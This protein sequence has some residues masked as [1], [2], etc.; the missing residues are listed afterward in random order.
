MR[1]HRADAAGP[2]L[3]G[4]A[5]ALV[6]ARLHLAEALDLRL[7]LGAFNGSTVCTPASHSIAC[8]ASPT[9]ENSRSEPQPGK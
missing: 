9:C 7:P 5:A 8:V 4:V 2:R 6:E 1:Q 3:E